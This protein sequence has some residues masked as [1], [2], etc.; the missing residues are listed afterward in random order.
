M[1]LQFKQ[2]KFQTE[3]ANA[4]CDIFQGQ[5]HLTHEYQ[6]DSAIGSNLS[7][8]NTGWNN[9]PI[10]PSVEHEILENVIRQQKSQEIPISNKLDSSNSCPINLTIEMETGVGKTYTYIKTIYELNKRYGWCKFIIVVPSIAIREGIASSFKATADHFQSLY[11]SRIRYFIYNSKQLDEVKNFATSSAINVMIINSQAFNAKGKDARRMYMKLDDFGGIQPIDVIART[12][13]ILIIDEP[14]SVEGKETKE[15]LKKFNAMMMLRYSATHRKDSIYNM[16][17]RL[18][19][20]DAYNKKLVKKIAVKG[21][22][23]KGN[24]ASDGYIYI[25]SINLSESY[26]TAT[27][28]FDIKTKDKTKR[29]TKTVDEGFSLY[30]QSG[31]LE[32]YK[33]IT[34]T[35]IR[36]DTNTVEFSNGLKLK[37]GEVTNKAEE[38]DFRRIQIIETIKAHIEKE[39]TLFKKGIK[40]LSLFFIDE[41]AKYRIYTDGIASNGEYAEIF[42]LEYQRYLDEYVYPNKDNYSEEYIKYLKAITAQ[43][44]H[45]G[46]FS[47]DKKG[48][49]INS[50]ENKKEGGSDDVDAYD[51]IMKNKE[52]LLDLSPSKSPVRFIFSHSALRE[53]WDNPNVFQICTLKQANSEIKKRQE[54]GRGL[55]LCVNQKGERMDESVLGKDVHNINK[56]TVIA[57]ESYDEFSRAI[58]KEI[59]EVIHDRPLKVTTDLLEGIEIELSDGTKE[60]VDKEVALNI[61]VALRTQGYVD[62][63]NKLTDKYHDDAATGAFTLSDPDLVDYESAIQHQLERIYDG[64]AIIPEDANNNNVTVKLNKNNFAKKEF[65]ELWARINGKT[66]YLV[67]FDSNSLIQNAIKALNKELTVSEITYHVQEGEIQ[68][69]ESKHTI[70][71]GEA[72]TLNKKE[73]AK[74]DL[75]KSDYSKT[76]KID[77]IGKIVEAT[78]LTRKDIVA[79]LKGISPDTFNMYKKNPEEFILKSSNII[80]AEKAVTVVEKLTY[81]FTNEEFTTD[82]FTDSKAKGKLNVNTMPAEKHIFSHVIYDSEREKEFATELEKFSEVAVY[83]KLPRGFFISTPVG[84]YNPDWAIAFNQGT[85]KHIYFVAETKGTNDTLNLRKIEDAKIRCAEKH[86]EKL[87]ERISTDKV[88]YHHVKDFE[89]MLAIVRQ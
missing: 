77:L 73:I 25:E 32:E 20:V 24:V 30:D 15:S 6:I 62:K 59:S 76:I 63:S 2:Q 46:Y 79:I 87:C 70:D 38:K 19:A 82:I 41:V 56:L 66:M 23:R 53:G 34:V 4:V 55:R 45:E 52:R 13:P 50:K 37:V 72:F 80:N 89:T 84:K 78:G 75:Y 61:F 12:N 48:S 14:Q 40:V 5:P 85:V 43:S 29:V 42:E 58:Q 74:V 7:V 31:G 3:A 83:A 16:V 69:I 44:T 11:G 88:V 60:V 68:S 64:T 67:N 35:S 47:I 51:L 18:D 21:I 9:A 86:F 33:G 39:S 10:T 57:S 54:V 22:E 8:I 36:G 28:E 71:K 81:D 1:K 17:Y 49:L 27:I 26:P 65:K